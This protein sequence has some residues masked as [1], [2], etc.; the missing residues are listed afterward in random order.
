MKIY[1]GFGDKGKTR[2]YGSDIVEK[3]HL[4]VECYVTMDELNSVLGIVLSHCK[5]ERISKPLQRVQNNLFRLSTEL[6][7]PLDQLDKIQAFIL[8]QEDI[9]Q[10]EQEIDIVQKQL[11]PLQ[12][13]II[14]GGGSLAAFLHLARTVCRRGE[15]HIT[16]LNQQENVNPM[17]MVY[18]NR[19][20]DYLF[21]LAR[22][23]NK[24]AGIPDV[25]WNTAK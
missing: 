1:T 21:V 25:L 22:L 11:D 18:C 20:S 6:A 14:P 12:N 19:L 2:L 15:R 7:T 3:N 24:N 13:F 16:S 17:I 23:S 5:D 8:G 9:D 4:R 10:I